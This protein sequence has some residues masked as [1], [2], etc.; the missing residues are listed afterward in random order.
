MAENAEAYY[1]LALGWNKSW[2]TNSGTEVMA[3]GS[4]ADNIIPSAGD[5]AVNSELS[6]MTPLVKPDGAGVRLRFVREGAAITAYALNGTEWVQIGE[7]Q[8]AADAA[9]TITFWSA[10]NYWS[11]SDI[12][13]TNNSAE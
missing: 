9:T 4:Q 12:T 6:W 3:F 8:C 10:Y 7:T 11:F 2:D 5:T 13:V 1:G